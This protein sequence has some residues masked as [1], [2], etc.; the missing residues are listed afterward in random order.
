MAMSPQRKRS[1]TTG[2]VTIVILGGLIAASFALSK[3]VVFFRF[4]SQFDSSTISP[5]EPGDP[6]ANPEGEPVN[7]DV[8]PAPVETEPNLPAADP[9][10][11]PKPADSK[12]PAPEPP[13]E[14]AG[15]TNPPPA[16]PGATLPPVP[17]QY[18]DAAREIS[19]ADKAA[20]ARIILTKLSAADINRLMELGSGD[21]TAAKKD[22]AISILQSKLTP[23]ELEL[24]INMAYKYKDVIKRAIGK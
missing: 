18:A 12:P 7:P 8:I 3:A 11:T 22:E 24:V 13:T 15:P 14:P 17:D 9:A 19:T 21:I 1:L 20:A 5:A 23:E 16:E 6:A 4:F 2:V 10:D